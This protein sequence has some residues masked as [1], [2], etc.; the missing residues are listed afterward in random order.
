MRNMTS[1]KPSARADEGYGVKGRMTCL[2]STKDIGHSIDGLCEPLLGKPIN[3]LHV[4]SKSQ[5]RQTQF[6]W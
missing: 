3:Q 6:D 1:D 5:E 4:D 2:R